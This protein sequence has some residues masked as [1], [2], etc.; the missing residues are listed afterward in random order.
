MCISDSNDYLLSVNK[1]RIGCSSKK[2]KNK[3]EFHILPLCVGLGQA[4]TNDLTT[5]IIMY[6]SCQAFLA[7]F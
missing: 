2:K 1:T 3:Q 7:L 5:I 4:L 6:S